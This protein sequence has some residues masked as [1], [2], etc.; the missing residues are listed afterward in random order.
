MNDVLQKL[1]LAIIAIPLLTSCVVYKQTDYPPTWGQLKK[2]I[3]SDLNGIYFCEGDVESD[4]YITS[5]KHDNNL[6]YLLFG[7]AAQESTTVSLQIDEND[8]I[9]INA[10]RHDTL[11]FRKTLVKDIDFTK[12]NGWITI[13]N[14]FTG[15]G[16]GVVG[17][18]QTLK[19]IRLSENGNL[20]IK[21]TESGFGIVII[22]PAG[23]SAVYW[24]RY[25]KKTDHNLPIP[26]PFNSP[27][28]G[29]D[30]NE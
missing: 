14:K 15:A 25:K 5:E 12:E 13:E 17:Q 3:G 20:I 22:V 6:G 16:P 28:Q 21:R 29:G 11:I 4:A 18:Q 19:Q 1:L 8:N 24:Y 10:F 7:Q 2:E 30:S 26:F 27:Q 9:F 23:G